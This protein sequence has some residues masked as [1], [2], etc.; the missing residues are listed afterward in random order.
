MTKPR[1]NSLLQ[2]SFEVLDLEIDERQANDAA[3]Q[4]ARVTADPTYI[5]L[6][7]HYFIVRNST[8]KNPEKDNR[9]L[10]VLQKSQHKKLDLAVAIYTI[11]KY[12]KTFPVTAAVR[13][14]LEDYV[15]NLKADQV[16][17]LPEREIPHYT[18][19]TYH[20]LFRAQNPDHFLNTPLGN[21]TLR[22]RAVAKKISHTNWKKAALGAL[23]FFGG[24]A[25]VC[26]AGAS[27]AASAG[28][29]TPFALALAKVGLEAAAIGAVY[30][31]TEVLLACRRKS[32]KTGTAVV[33][34]SLLGAGVGNS[35]FSAYHATTAG[36]VK[37]IAVTSGVI[38]GVTA[39]SSSSVIGCLGGAYSVAAIGGMAAM[40]RGAC[41]LYSSRAKCKAVYKVASRFFHPK[42]IPKM[43]NDGQQKRDE[44]LSLSRSNSFSISR[45]PS[46]SSTSLSPSSSPSSLM[47]SFNFSK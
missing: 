44:S 36:A 25:L 20:M 42:P 14:V 13:D 47:R 43:E 19:L 29:T 10:E 16:E 1:L 11:E 38:K 3:R 34:S 32:W 35:L 37:D 41:L 45:T 4:Q 23:L 8:V 28:A 26:I 7:N 18:E 33:M 46:F 24:A 9:M 30:A 27:I 40:V 22:G 12:A 6:V 5:T 39:T 31:F 21:N 15:E 17:N 2:N